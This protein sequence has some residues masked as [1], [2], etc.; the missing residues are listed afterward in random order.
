VHRVIA[1]VVVIVRLKKAAQ[2]LARQQV[3]RQAQRQVL[4]QAQQQAAQRLQL[5]LRLPQ[6]RKLLRLDS[7]EGG[8]I[9][10]AALV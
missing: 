9:H 7:N 4:T 8:C 2:R 1:R 6:L 3:P 5:P 10:A